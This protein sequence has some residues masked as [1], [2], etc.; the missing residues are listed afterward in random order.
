MKGKPY[1]IQYGASLSLERLATR[2][3]AV[4]AASGKARKPRLYT[5][6]NNFVAFRRNGPGPKV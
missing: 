2:T 5:A 4:Q 6:L 1:F 3:I